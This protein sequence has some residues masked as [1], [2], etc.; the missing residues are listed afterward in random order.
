M[1]YYLWSFPLLF[2]D[3]DLVVFGGWEQLPLHT[4][5]DLLVTA[6]IS[7]REDIKVI[8]SARVPIV[9]LT[10]QQTG[11]KVDISFNMTTGVA[12]AQMTK[13]CC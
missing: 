6:G 11:I 8:E 1:L 7:R 2:S 5:G 4:L 12:S 10:D 9:K 3:I 13:V